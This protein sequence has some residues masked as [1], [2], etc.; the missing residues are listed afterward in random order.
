MA[1]SQEYSIFSVISITKD[2]AKKLF[3]IQNNNF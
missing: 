1:Y 2:E 3:L